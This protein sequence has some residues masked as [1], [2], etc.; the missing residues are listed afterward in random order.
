MNPVEDSK[1]EDTMERIKCLSDPAEER[2]DKD[3]KNSELSFDK[4]WRGEEGRGHHGV[5]QTF[6]EDCICIGRGD[7]G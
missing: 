4:S 6:E 2:K 1:D 5:E 7:Q 3:N